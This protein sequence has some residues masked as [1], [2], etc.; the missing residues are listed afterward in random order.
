[1]GLLKAQ[2]TIEGTRP[3]L[4]HAFSL[5]SI[6][7]EKKERSGTAGNE[8]NEWKRSVLVVPE[9]NQLYVEPT[10]IFG[11][12]RDGGKQLKSGKGTFQSKVSS[13]LMVLNEIVLIDRYLPPEKELTQDKKAP[14]Y[15]DVRSIKNPSTRAR[16]IRYRIAASPGWKASFE[17][18]WEGTIV[19]REQM[20]AILNDAGRFA[21]LGDG[22]SIGFG[23]F[24]IDKFKVSE[25]KK[26]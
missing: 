15:L 11:C 23:R 20:K 16:N 21:G 17:I 19:S 8:P 7:L 18:E 3:I 10:Y 6:P 1:M 9:T 4:F 12:I 14:V 13:T 22:R 25:V 24:V 5:D 2:V 26:I